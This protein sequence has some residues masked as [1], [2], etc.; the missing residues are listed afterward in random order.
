M[1]GFIKFC[2]YGKFIGLLGV[3]GV[4]L[5]TS[6]LRFFWLFWLLGLVEIIS[7]LPVFFQ[8]I[9][10]ALSM[11]IVPLRFRKNI[12]DKNNITNQTLFSLPFSE[13]WAAVNGGGGSIGWSARYFL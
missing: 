3:L 13:N 2:Q 7:N 12:S 10:L 5:D 8:N 1:K 11:L 9:K 4:I 6:V